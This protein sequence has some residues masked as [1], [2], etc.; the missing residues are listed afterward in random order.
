VRPRGPG[1]LILFALLALASLILIGV[2]GSRLAAL[3]RGHR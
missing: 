2:A 1:P 3:R